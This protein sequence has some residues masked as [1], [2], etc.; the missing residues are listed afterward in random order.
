LALMRKG[1][2]VPVCP[3]VLGG[4]P[5][6]R[7]PAEIIAEGDKQSVSLGAVVRTVNGVDV[8]RQYLEGARRALFLGLQAGCSKAILKARSP[9]CGLGKVYDGTFSKRLRQGHGVFA[10]LLVSYGIE[11][12]TE[13]DPR[14]LEL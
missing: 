14:I 1:L 4:L 5:I 12:Y 9:S 13:E 3:E 11:V 6:P 10:E 8:T 7:A 2:G